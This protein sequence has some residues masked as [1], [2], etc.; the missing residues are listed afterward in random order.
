MRRDLGSPHCG[1][2]AASIALERGIT[3]AVLGQGKQV[4]LALRRR[5]AHF[6]PLTPLLHHADRPPPFQLSYEGNFDARL[7][8]CAGLSSRIQKLSVWLFSGDYLHLCCVFQSCLATV[9]MRGF[10]CG[11]FKPERYIKTWGMNVDADLSDHAPSRLQALPT[12]LQKS[13]KGTLPFSWLTF[14]HCAH[15]RFASS[16]SKI[17]PGPSSSPHQ[18]LLVNDRL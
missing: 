1:S 18:L 14:T 2:S 16:P 10:Q 8:R 12:T 9:E 11:T 17:P 4:T 7:H 3:R 6:I 5:L 15:V 13:V